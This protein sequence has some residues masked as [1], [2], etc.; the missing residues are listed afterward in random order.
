VFGNSL[1]NFDVLI[2]LRDRGVGF[3]FT[4]REFV[5][6]VQP[7]ALEQPVKGNKAVGF[8]G[9][10]T[11]ENLV[12]FLFS[13]G[14]RGFNQAVNAVNAVN[15]FVIG[16]GDL[17]YRNPESLKG[18]VPPSLDVFTHFGEGRLFPS[19]A[20]PGLSSLRL[21]CLRS[22]LCPGSI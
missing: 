1:K 7:S 13:P 5:R 10:V 17:L 6:F 12:F 2:N 4:I 14:F 9:K 20:D 8:P 15:G 19:A 11:L 3:R 18:G 16:G 22:G 21:F